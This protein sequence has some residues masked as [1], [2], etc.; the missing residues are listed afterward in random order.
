MEV[1][2]ALITVVFVASLSSVVR[3]AP[4]KRSPST[5]DI[6]TDV[7]SRHVK[8]ATQEVCI[9]KWL[10]VFSKWTIW[11]TKT[12]LPDQTSKLLFWKR[13]FPHYS[14]IKNWEGITSLQVFLHYPATSASTEN[15]VGQIIFRTCH[16]N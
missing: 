4:V 7:I 2:K 1:S 9:G 3:S 5:I 16:F 13:R 6:L 15:T 11:Q 8:N 14:K 10:S 12:A